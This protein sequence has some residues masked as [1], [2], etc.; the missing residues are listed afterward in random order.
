MKTKVHTAVRV[1]DL[2]RSVEFYAKLFESIY[3]SGQ[4]IGLS[5][6]QKEQSYY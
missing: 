2:K 5:L 3:E 1:S 4:T 6:K